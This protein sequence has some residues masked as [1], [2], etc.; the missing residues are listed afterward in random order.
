MAKLADEFAFIRDR[1]ESIE[2][3]RMQALVGVATGEP[4]SETNAVA[5]IDWG[6]LL[7][8]SSFNETARQYMALGCTF[9]LPDL[10]GRVK[11]SG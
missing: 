8:P 6:G 9:N 7:S 3:E 5:A 2:D 1:L 10:R 4:N 11:L